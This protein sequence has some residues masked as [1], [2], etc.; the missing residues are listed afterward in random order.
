MSVPDDLKLLGIA[1]PLAVMAIKW[2]RGHNDRTLT[3]P[4]GPRDP[5]SDTD[6]EQMVRSGRYI[7]AI[8]AARAR[9]G[10]DLKQAKQHV[11]AIK[12][13]RDSP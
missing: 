13:G 5:A 2:L 10:Y 3:P 11:D 9:H 6:I 12:A 4:P 1:L 8:K 7:E